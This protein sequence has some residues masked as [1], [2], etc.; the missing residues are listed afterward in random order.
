MNSASN[1]ATDKI[2]AD[3]DAFSFENVSE[4]STLNTASM[5]AQ[6]PMDNDEKYKVL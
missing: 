5:D 1:G 6:I 2:D 3:T 4:K